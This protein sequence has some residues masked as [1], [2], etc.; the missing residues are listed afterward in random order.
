MKETYRIGDSSIT[1]TAAANFIAQ[2]LFPVPEHRTQSRRISDKVKRAQRAGRLPLI[3]AIPADVFFGWAI[4]QNGWQGLRKIPGI[5][6]S[7]SVLIQGV[8][9]TGNTAEITSAASIPEDYES[10]KAEL[11]RAIAEIDQLKH[12]RDILQAQLTKY[13][14]TERAAFIRNSENGKM[15]GRGNEK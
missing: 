6:I 4:E 2:Q 8:S 14:R 15:G 1:R 9:G 3:E 11:K 12:Q 10:L 5:P 13:E 7:T